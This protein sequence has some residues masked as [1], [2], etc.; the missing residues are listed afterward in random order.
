VAWES[1]DD[2]NVNSDS[3]KLEGSVKSFVEDSVTGV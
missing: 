1:V 3:S 2:N